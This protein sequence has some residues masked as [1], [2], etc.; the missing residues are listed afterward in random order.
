MILA[1]IVSLQVASVAR[2]NGPVQA[3]NFFWVQLQNLKI[4]AGQSGGSNAVEQLVTESDLVTREFLSS[5]PDLGVLDHHLRRDTVIRTHLGSAEFQTRVIGP[6]NEI[7]ARHAERLGLRF[8]EGKGSLLSWL[9]GNTHYGSGPSM[10]AAYLDMRAREFGMSFSEWRA[11]ALDLRSRL[12]RESVQY[13][14]SWAQILR[15]SRRLGRDPPAMTAWGNENGLPSRMSDDIRE[16]GRL[17]TM[18]DYLPPGT[19]AEETAGGAARRNHFLRQASSSDF[20]LLTDVPDLGV[21]NRLEQDQWLGRGAPVEEL[22]GVHGAGTARIME[23]NSRV[24]S[25]L[26]QIGPG[27]API[28]NLVTAGDETAWAISGLSPEQ[29]HLVQ[30]G[31]RGVAGVYFSIVPIDRTESGDPV[32]QAIDRA[33]SV[34]EKVSPNCL[35]DVLKEI[36]MSSP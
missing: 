25:L 11:S 14:I 33:R 19:A 36:R 18:A 28:P 34:M 30:D 3:E 1:A 8:P 15:A 27:K 21:H 32:N 9:G 6:I 22:G 10:E 29:V 4:L 24:E 26:N 2:A 5:H 20:I 17:L 31:L 35:S 7:L 12:M 23:I 16:Y 13:G